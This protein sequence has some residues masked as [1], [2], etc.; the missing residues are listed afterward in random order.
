MSNIP[1][2]LLAFILVIG[3]LIFAHEA[4][5]F[6]FAKLFRVRV[7]VFSFGFGKRL[8]GFHRGDTD[9]RVSL[10]PLGGYVRMA[11][12]NPEENEQ[13]ADDE[14]LSK[15][16]WQ[17]FLILFAGPA[18]NIL[19]AIAF[20]AGIVM[21]GTEYLVIR[22]VV[23]EVLPDRAAARAG[24][25][26]GDHIIRIGREPIRDFNDL[27]LAIS[28]NAGTPLEVEFIRDGQRQTTIVTPEREQ[29]E[30]G[31][32]GRIGIRP[33]RDPI[34]G[35]VTPGSPAD[36]AGLRPGDRI[37]SVNG[38]PISNLDRLNEVLAKAPGAPLTLG[39][40]RGGQQYLARFPQVEF[41]PRDPYRGFLPPMETRKLP[42]VPA[43]KE[44]VQ[45]NWKM[46]RYAGAAVARMFR[47]EGSVKELSGPISIARISGDMFRRGWMEVVALM[48]MIS[49]Q[50]GVL[51]LLPI[52]VL[53][54]GHIMILLIEGIAR[55]DLSIRVKERIQQFGFAVLAALMI[56]VLYN[57]VISNVLM[58]RRG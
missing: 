22:P 28:L 33:L 27:H 43:L 57:D 34:V 14:F 19:I 26:V 18:M 24:L 30:Y 29:S 53:D 13:G 44:S 6:M 12:D 32:V 9:Y 48:A 54:G 4:G 5:H 8:F 20:M 46:L 25:Q 17:R 40:T 52:P 35:R 41:N 38:Q 31:P 3:F 21:V 37:I 56:V 16:K 50:L 1:T 15:P 47:P 58:M 49:L 45:Q 55:R 36:Q 42:L 10:I 23:G 39:M 7:L 11:G 51:N 2:N